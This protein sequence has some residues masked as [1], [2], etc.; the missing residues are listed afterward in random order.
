ME[1]GGAIVVQ[2]PEGAAH[3]LGDRT[4]KQGHQLGSQ[5]E[6]NERQAG[7]LEELGTKLLGRG[8]GELL[9]KPEAVSIHHCRVL[10]TVLQDCRK[11]PGKLRA[12]S[13]V[14][15]TTGDQRQEPEEDQVSAQAK[16]NS[17]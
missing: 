6:S 17:R 16:A 12:S 2:K 13:T 1:A 8:A 7:I 15:T 9:D 14:T 4:G 5:P 3:G 10:I 11:H